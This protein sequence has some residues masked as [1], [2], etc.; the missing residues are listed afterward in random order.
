MNNVNRYIMDHGLCY[1]MDYILKRC[2]DVFLKCVSASTIFSISFSVNA[3]SNFQDFTIAL[4]VMKLKVLS[5]DWEI[6]W[7]LRAL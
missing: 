7:H 4:Q 2:R 1:R 3:G 5:Q 6:F